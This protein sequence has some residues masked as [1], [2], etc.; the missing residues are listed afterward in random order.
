MH[1]PSYR[2]AA[3]KHAIQ[4]NRREFLGWLG[5]NAPEKLHFIL[6]FRFT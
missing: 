2:A 4:D 5:V 3:Q 6:E 1:F